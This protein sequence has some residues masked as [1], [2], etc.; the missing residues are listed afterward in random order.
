MSKVLIVGGG[1]T[2]AVTACLLNQSNKFANCELSIWDKARGSGGR[3]STSRLTSTTNITFSADL[4]AQYITATSD[5]AKL[6]AEYYNELKSKNILTPL[7]LPIEGQKSNAPGTIDYVCPKG[8]SSIVKHYF[9][10][11]AVDVK[12][13][14]RVL[15]LKNNVYNWIV[16]TE[17]G[18]TESFDAVILTMPAPQILELLSNSHELNA[19]EKQD[20]D[21]I[22][23]QLQKVTYSS[24]YA[25]ALLYEGKD[26]N[27]KKLIKEKVSL[28]NGSCAKYIYGDDIFRY[29][30]LDNYKRCNTLNPP[31]DEL[32]PMSVVFHTSVPFGL[33][34]VEKS[35]EDV[36]PLLLEH[37]DRLF[38]S[39]PKPSQV[40][41][42]KWRYSQVQTA[43][44]EKPGAIE[45][46]K[47]PLLLAGGD[48][49]THS[50]F[51][52]CITS[53]EAIVNK[54][55]ECLQ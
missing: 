45:L 13:G 11:S 31:I 43:Y 27:D 47:T 2:S 32:V 46:Q 52:G 19:S 30:S 7:N 37:I 6:H 41:C 21:L 29:V 54:Y 51:D 20:F 34:H 4:G 26:E 22:T 12:F 25:I 38:P 16:T 48:A 42:Q 49:F 14:K 10:K 17:S 36:K 40:K 55:F 53:A 35:P 24:R 23:S 28:E 18:D 44:A 39:W 8:S 5:Y 3:M 50:N 9:K 33:K 15:S 1:L